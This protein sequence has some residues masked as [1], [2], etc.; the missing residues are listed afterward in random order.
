MTP[1]VSFEQLDPADLPGALLSLPD[2]PRFDCIHNSIGAG[3]QVYL[4]WALRDLELAENESPGNDQDRLCVNAV[5]SARRAVSCLADQYLKREGISFCKNPPREAK[6]ISEVLIARNV[7]SER[8][9]I[10]LQRA[11]DVR[12]R[13]EHQYQSIGL[14][15]TQEL[16]QLIHMT[17]EYTVNRSSPFT[18]PFLYGIVEGGAGLGPSGV[19]GTFGGWDGCCF[20]SMTFET[21]PWFGIVQP[22]SKFEATVRR[23]FL[24]ILQ[25][26]STCPY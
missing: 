16:I 8:A 15:D 22:S 25:F 10:C 3:Y 24:R 7:F 18:S 1:K 2:V 12:N 13:I 5:M 20:V 9:A 17:V 26:K 11:V 21:R 6:A 19:Y 4:A 23:A 14:R